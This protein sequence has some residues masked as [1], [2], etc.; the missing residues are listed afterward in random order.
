[1]RR[2]LHVVAGPPGGGKSTYAEK[3]A[4][5]KG[6]VVDLDRMAMDRSP[7]GTKP[8]RYSGKARASAM[9]D[10][11]DMIER[12]IASPKK[13]MVVVDTAPTKKAMKRYDDAGAKKHMMDPGEKKT[14]RRVKE[15]RP[16]HFKYPARNWYKNDKARLREAGYKKPMRNIPNKYFSKS[17]FEL[18]PRLKGIELKGSD[19]INWPGAMRNGYGVKK[20][21]TTTI[22]AHKYVYEQSTGKKTPKGWQIDHTCRNRKCINPK[23][24][25][26]V[27][28]GDN[29]KRAWDFKLGKYKHKNYKGESKDGELI[30]VKPK[31]EKAPVEAVKVTKSLLGWKEYKNAKT[32]VRAAK[33][34]TEAAQA[35][36]ARRAKKLKTHELFNDLKEH[37]DQ[38][39][40][41]VKRAAM[42]AQKR[43][44]KTMPRTGS[45]ESRTTSTDFSK[46]GAYKERIR[47][48]AF[49]DI[50]MPSAQGR[51]Y[52]FPKKENV[53]RYRHATRISNS[54]KE[55]IKA[56]GLRGTRNAR[57]NEAK[58]RAGV[59]RAKAGEEQARKTANKARNDA[60]IRTGLV[61]TGGATGIS[62]STLAYKKRKSEKAPV[63]VT[64]VSK[65]IPVNRITTSRLT[66]GSVP[67]TSLNSGS[68]PFKAAAK[69]KKL[70]ELKANSRSQQLVNHAR[71]SVSGPSAKWH[72]K[73]QE[74][75]LRA[76]KKNRF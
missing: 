56:A 24:L 27:S 59:R 12:H 50:V 30:L 1:M 66:S 25:E 40:V 22:P 68:S 17:E 48:T 20:L 41:A 57:I 51:D 6:T 38:S 33:K 26:A 61:S 45:F 16:D 2:D 19:C 62:A 32:G 28:P 3:K 9:K 43:G 29:K 31:S 42:S 52:N 46:P 60:I 15:G 67:K 53:A 37:H 54:R 44:Y 73:Q 13:R 71:N 11:S 8:Y 7:A 70:E 72:M 64:E 10:R 5:R 55:K 34:V 35:T 47:R 74:N 23:H 58:A 75:L 4:G 63:T 65:R 18:G 76:S 14:M 69:A 39:R 49:T 36:Q 21:G